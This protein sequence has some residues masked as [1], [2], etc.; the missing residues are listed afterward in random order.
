MWNS[1]GWAADAQKTS[2][3]APCCADLHAISIGEHGALHTDGAYDGGAIPH[4]L[5]SVDAGI[6]PAN[7]VAKD[8]DDAEYLVLSQICCWSITLGNEKEQRRS[9]NALGPEEFCPHLLGVKF[10]MPSRN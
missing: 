3:R 10:V 6:G 5:L 7:V 9:S 4:A 8:N 2:Q 1:I